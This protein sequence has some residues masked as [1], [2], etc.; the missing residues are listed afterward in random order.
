MECRPDMDAGNMRNQLDEGERERGKEGRCW[1]GLSS[2]AMARK[3]YYLIFLL[4]GG[5]MAWWKDPV[6][7]KRTCIEQVAR[8]WMSGPSQ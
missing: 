4:H 5:Y 8:F 6:L 2:P 3:D 1:F 7:C